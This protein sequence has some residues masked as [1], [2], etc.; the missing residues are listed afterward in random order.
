MLLHGELDG[1][2]KGICTICIY[3]PAYAFICNHT[4]YLQLQG[5]TM[6]FNT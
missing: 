3:M 6:Q 1:T 5:N 2:D 4:L